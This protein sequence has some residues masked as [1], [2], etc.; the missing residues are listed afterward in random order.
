MNRNNFYLTENTQKATIKLWVLYKWHYVNA[1]NGKLTRVKQYHFHDFYR[2]RNETGLQRAERISE[3]NK[4]AIEQAKIYDHQVNKLLK[5][6]D[7]TYMSF[8]EA[9]NEEIYKDINKIKKY[10]H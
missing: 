4:L 9:T 3:Q 5:I 7:P 6:F 1:S 10:S 8:R 2:G